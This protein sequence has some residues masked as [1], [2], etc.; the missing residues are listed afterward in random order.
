MAPFRSGIGLLANNVNLPIVPVRLDGVF[1]LKQRGARFARPGAVTV[2][3]GVPARFE[4]GVD[5]EQIA[6]EL[7]RRVAD[8]YRAS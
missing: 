6:R 8:L 5:P 3:I 2:T 7:E 1:E 4:P